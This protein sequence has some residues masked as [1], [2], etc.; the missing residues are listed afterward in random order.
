M[1]SSGSFSANVSVNFSIAKEEPNNVATCEAFLANNEITICKEI[2]DLTSIE[3]VHTKLTEHSEYEFNYVD[4]HDVGCEVY[5]LEDI[6]DY[7]SEDIT[8]HLT[9]KAGIL[10]LLNVDLDLL[11]KHK[12]HSYNENQT[13][14]IQI[15]YAYDSIYYENDNRTVESIPITPSLLELLTLPKAELILTADGW[16]E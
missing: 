10:D 2:P 12:I 13:T 5:N 16:A 9:R 11:V 4:L 8:L 14:E 15:L 1:G 3:E 6:E 7:S